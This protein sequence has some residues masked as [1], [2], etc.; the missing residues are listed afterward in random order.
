VAL[1][2]MKLIFGVLYVSLNYV[3]YTFL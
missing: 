2:V 1:D 3:P